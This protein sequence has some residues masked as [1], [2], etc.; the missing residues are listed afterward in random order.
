M[1]FIWNDIYLD[2]WICAFIS[3]Y[4]EGHRARSRRG[5]R[6]RASGEPLPLRVE[7]RK[8]GARSAARP[9]SAA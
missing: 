8:R 7:L 1:F 6:S 5:R 2:F 9:R 3:S 4:I